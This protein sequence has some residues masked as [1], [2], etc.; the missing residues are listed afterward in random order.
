MITVR[1]IIEHAKRGY[2]TGPPFT[3]ISTMAFSFLKLKI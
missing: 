3:K 2:M 1:A